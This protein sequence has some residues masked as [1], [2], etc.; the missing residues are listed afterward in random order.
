MEK[1]IILK[2]LFVFII[3]II[4]FFLK[5][6]NLL[7]LLGTLLGLIGEG[8]GGFLLFVWKILIFIFGVIFFK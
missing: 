6:E 2:R 8:K 1:L 5:V 3:K 7:Y 4:I